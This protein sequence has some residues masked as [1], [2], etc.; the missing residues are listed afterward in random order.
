VA[1]TVPFNQEIANLMYANKG[2]PLTDCLQCGTCSATCPAVGFMDHTPRALIGLIN[3]GYKD[4]VINSNTYWTCASC[5]H[6]TVRCPAQIDIAGMMYSLKRYSVWRHTADEELIG[7]QFSESFIKM[8][9]RRG[10]SYEPILAPTYMFKRGVRGVID[11]A[12]VGTTLMFKG[13][14]P[15]LPAKINR[16]DNFRRMVKRIIPVGGGS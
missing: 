8:I 5:Y 6:C 10:R 14:L 16:L 2:S 11:E 9:M 12:L 4:D 1:Q 7:P 15:I 3:A 13:R